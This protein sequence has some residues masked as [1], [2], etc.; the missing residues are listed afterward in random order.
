MSETVRIV[1]C[2]TCRAEVRWEPQ[3]RYRP[4]CSER[5]RLIDLG[6]WA[7]ES[8]KVPAQEESPPGETLPPTH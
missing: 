3:S 1:A 4:F 6:Q 5:C 2:P 8:Y 7:S